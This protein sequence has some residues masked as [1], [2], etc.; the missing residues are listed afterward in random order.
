MQLDRESV[1][2]KGKEGGERG[3]REGEFIVYSYLNCIHI[4]HFL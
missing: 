1:K 3:R 4:I 2:V